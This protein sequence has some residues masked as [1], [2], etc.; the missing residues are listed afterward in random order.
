MENLNLEIGKIVENSK[1]EIKQSVIAQVKKGV[2]NQLSF[3]MECQIKE[4]VTEFFEKEIKEDIVK[5]MQDS[6]EQILSEIKKGIIESCGELAKALT[7]KATKN[8][9]DSWKLGKITKELLDF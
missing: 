1:E 9:N 3:Q 7:T 6:K 4:I 8:I 2:E 5:M